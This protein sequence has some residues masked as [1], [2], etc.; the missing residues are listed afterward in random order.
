MNS[1]KRLS[2]Q[3]IEK[4]V[5][6]HSNLLDLYL[7]PLTEEIKSELATFCEKDRKKSL[8]LMQSHYK[9]V[10]R[11]LLEKSCI[12][13]NLVKSFG[14]LSPENRFSSKSCLD[15]SVIAKALPI[16]IVGDVLIDEWK[17]LQLDQNINSNLSIDKQ[18]NDLLNKKNVPKF[19]NCSEICINIMA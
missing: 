1:N 16:D 14:C 9:A 13:D 5:L 19:R 7:I 15:I 11:H 12:T 17:L 3:D 10:C 6:T 18:W 2:K 4:D 8:K